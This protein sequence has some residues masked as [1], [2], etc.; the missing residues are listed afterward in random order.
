[1]GGCLLGCVLSARTAFGTGVRISVCVR[2]VLVWISVVCVVLIRWCVMTMLGRVLVLLVIKWSSAVL[3]PVM[4]SV[5]R[6][7]S[8]LV[9][10]SVVGAVILWCDRVSAWLHLVRVLVVV[11]SVRPSVVRVLLC[12]VVTVVWARLRVVLCMV[13][14]VWVA[15]RVSL[16]N[17][18]PLS[19]VMSRFVV[20]WLFLEIGRAVTCVL[21][22]LQGSLI[23]TML[24]WGTSWVRL[25]ML[26]GMTALIMVGGRLTLGG[27][28]TGVSD[29]VFGISFASLKTRCSLGGRKHTLIIVL[30][31]TSRGTSGSVSN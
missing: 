29:F 9:I 10:L 23:A 2:L 13:I 3:V 22:V 11:V 14:L 20:M 16:R 28:V 7:W 4:V 21:L 31:S 18:R 19:A 25:I 6:S 1:M 5:A 26:S 17:G 27:R 8:V 15:S 30:S 24:L 12:E